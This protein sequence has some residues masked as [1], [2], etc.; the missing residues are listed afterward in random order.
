MAFRLSKCGSFQLKETNQQIE[1]HFVTTPVYDSAFAGQG[2]LLEIY[3]QSEKE[4]W[5]FI[6]QISIPNLVQWLKAGF[7]FYWFYLAS[8]LW[9]AYYSSIANTWADG[10][11][12]SFISLFFFSF[13]LTDLQS[14]FVV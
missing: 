4:I 5:L 14:A 9:P 10:R 7:T 3:R 13:G 12:I 11:K 6:L 1:P 2:T 8:Q